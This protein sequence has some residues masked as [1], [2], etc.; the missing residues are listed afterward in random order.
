[1][2]KSTYFIFRA[3]YAYFEIKPFFVS[4]LYILRSLSTMH[5]NKHSYANIY[6]KYFINYKA[7]Y[8]CIYLFLGDSLSFFTNANTPVI[9]V[10]KINRVL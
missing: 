7:F 3:T 4:L 5:L 2:N 8:N 6:F 10:V 1:M 9:F